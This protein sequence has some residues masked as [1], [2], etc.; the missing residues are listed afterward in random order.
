MSLAS[1]P[2]NVDAIELSDASAW[3]GESA[4]GAPEAGGVVAPIDALVQLQLEDV[5]RHHAPDAK[6]VG[7]WKSKLSNAF[8]INNSAG[9]MKLARAI[10]LVLLSFFFVLTTSLL[11]TGFQG[12]LPALIKD[13]VRTFVSHC[14]ARI[15]A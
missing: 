3:S 6:T 13:G 1:I 11:V 15:C 9:G 12:L 7:T 2:S 10:V 8:R 4:I 14:L 5:L